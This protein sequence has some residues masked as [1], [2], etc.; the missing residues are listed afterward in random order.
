MLRRDYSVLMKQQNKRSFSRKKLEEIESNKG[1][2]RAILTALPTGGGSLVGGYLAKEEADRADE[3]GDSD[4]KILK[5]ARNKGLKTGAMT[6]AAMG[7]LGAVLGAAGGNGIRG[8][9]AIPITAALGALGG[10][11]AA[12]VN[13][14][15]RLK[16][17]REK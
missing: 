4:E 2:K 17:R 15:D 1:L 13:T 9:A 12:G 11:N 8:V 6:G 3:E 7:T 14:K 10:R 16:K 5:R